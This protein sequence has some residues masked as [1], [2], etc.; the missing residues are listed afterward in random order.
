MSANDSDHIMP[1]EEHNYINF[2]EADIAADLESPSSY[3][4]AIASSAAAQW[5]AG[6]VAEIHGQ[7]LV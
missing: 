1:S 7:R 3:A 5:I 2:V 6:F 4:E